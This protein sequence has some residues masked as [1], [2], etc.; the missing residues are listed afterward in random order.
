M[1]TTTT[2]VGLL[3]AMTFIGLPLLT[4]P[5]QAVIICAGAVCQETEV[6]SDLTFQTWTC[7]GS[8][9]VIIVTGD[10][11]NV[12]VCNGGNNRTA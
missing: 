4:P 11:N 7:G 8:G 3:M 6:N 2:L 10:H 9:N 5:A 12:T 1:K